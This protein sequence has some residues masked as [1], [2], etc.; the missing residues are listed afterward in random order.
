M[1]ILNDLQVSRQAG[2]GKALPIGWVNP[3][4]DRRETSDTYRGVI[5]RLGA[6][7]IA[8]C[9]NNLHCVVLTHR[10]H[11]GRASKA[12]RDLPEHFEPEGAR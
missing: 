1:N 3:K 2:N 9:R 6:F 12:L 11:I 8:V 5:G 4:T 10:S 7:H